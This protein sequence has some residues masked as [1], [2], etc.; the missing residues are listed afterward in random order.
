MV[1]AAKGS[2]L[3][4]L[5]PPFKLGLGGK[6]GSGRQW[7]SWITLDDLIGI[8]VRALT[9]KALAAV[10]AFALRLAFGEM[11]DAML[12][13]STRVVPARLNEIGYRFRYPDMEAA[14]RSIILTEN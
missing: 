5:L 8:I 7:M 1:L 2:A 13:A 4:R 12:L 14:L 9:D 11:A 6:L 10:P 3:A